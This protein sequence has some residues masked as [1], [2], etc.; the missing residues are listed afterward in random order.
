MVVF[1]LLVAQEKDPSR[2][3]D[4]TAPADVVVSG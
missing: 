3:Y 4:L 2:H 1:N